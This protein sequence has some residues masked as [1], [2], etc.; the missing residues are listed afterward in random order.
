MYFMH[1]LPFSTIKTLTLWMDHAKSLDVLTSLT[2][3][4][5]ILPGA[6]CFAMSHPASH[7]ICSFINSSGYAPGPI[8]RCLFIDYII[9]SF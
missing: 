3:S 7:E 5:S 2:L 1:F 8:K 9:K 6:V 4:Q